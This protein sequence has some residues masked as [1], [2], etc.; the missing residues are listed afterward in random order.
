ML[1]AF[2]EDGSLPEGLQSATE[3]EVFARFAPPSARR[4]WLADRLR[5][6]LDLAK[7]T[8]QLSRV[9][10]WGSFVT[11]KEVPND[12]DVLLVM[13]EEFSVDAC[14]GACRVLFNHVEARL[15]FNADVF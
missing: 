4:Q 10:V 11:S 8:G 1:P 12:L 7:A 5:D 15:C 9:V 6:L 13:T 3:D 2:N 14:P